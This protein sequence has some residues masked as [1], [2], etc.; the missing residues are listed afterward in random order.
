MDEMLE[1]CGVML[2]FNE[3]PSYLHITVDY[4]ALQQDYTSVEYGDN[5]YWYR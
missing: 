2:P 3:I 1:D 4:D 5:T